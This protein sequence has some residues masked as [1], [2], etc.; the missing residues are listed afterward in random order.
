MFLSY[1][2]ITDGVMLL[3]SQGH[4]LFNPILIIFIAQLGN[5]AYLGVDSLTW[6]G[7]GNLTPSQS[8]LEQ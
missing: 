7:V 2:V 3:L 4:D 6:L 5:F 8:D 1:V